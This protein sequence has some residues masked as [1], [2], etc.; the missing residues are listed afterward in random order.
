MLAIVVCDGLVTRP[1]SIH[2]FHI[3]NGI[4]SSQT[5]EFG[6]KKLC[7]IVKIFPYYGLTN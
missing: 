7:F 3:A 2:T 1:V 5:N 4:V 6:I